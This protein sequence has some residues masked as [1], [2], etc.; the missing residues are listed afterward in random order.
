M[1]VIFWL[2]IERSRVQIPAT[3][4]FFNENHLFQLDRQ[5]VMELVQMI[6]IDER[7]F[8]STLCQAL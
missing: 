6:S 2:M 7:Q 8:N 3:D 4:S 5:N 1:V